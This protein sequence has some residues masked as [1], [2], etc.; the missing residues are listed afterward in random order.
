[1]T[2]RILLLL[3]LTLVIATSASATPPPVDPYPRD[4]MLRVSDIWSIG[5]HNSYH[6]R[7][8]LYPNGPPHDF[9]YAHEPLDVQLDEQGVRKFE[10]DVFWD[11]EEEFFHVHHFNFFDQN[12]NCT[13]LTMCLEVVRDWS[14]AHQ[15]HHPIFIFIEP[16]GLFFPSMPNVI[17]DE[18]ICDRPDHVICHYDELDAEIRSVLDPPGGPDILLT[19]DEVR[20]TNTTLREAILMDGWPTLRE[21]RGQIVVVMLDEGIDRAGYVE[22][23]ASLAGRAMFVTSQEGRDDAAVLKIDGPVSGFD[24]IQG[25]VALG[26]VIRTRADSLDDAQANDTTNRD[27]ALA[28]GAQV[29]ST[30]YPVPGILENGY[31]AAIPGGT[32]SGCNPITTFGIECVSED[33]ENPAALVVPEVG[34]VGAALAAMAGLAALWRARRVPRGL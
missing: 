16:K 19:P 5:T 34:S 4:D 11:A 10:L 24:R 26:Y 15:G 1:M 6:L 17:S 20:G 27:A 30:D 22:G 12:S 33:I 25:L 8:P 31:F 7:S 13:P 18:P 9:D 2:P 14:L 28:S 32:P 21:A 3:A 23:H 29:I